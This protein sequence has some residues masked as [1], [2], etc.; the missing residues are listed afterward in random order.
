MVASSDDIQAGMDVYGSDGEKI[1]TVHS[2]NTGE[3]GS[4]ADTAAGY[5]GGG[6]GALGD[7]SRVYS[8]TGTGGG[9]G[10]LGDESRVY[11]DT[12]TGGGPGS[13]GDES[14]VDN[15]YAATGTTSGTGSDTGATSAVTGGMGAGDLGP[16]M[17]VEEI[18]VVE[19]VPGSSYTATTGGGMAGGQ[20]GGYFE[21]DHGGF[22]GIGTQHLYIPYSAVQSVEPGSSVTLNC[23]KD[24]CANLYQNNPAQI[25]Q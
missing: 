4:D 13:L 7:E 5:S 24:E 18:E 19:I 22:L 1:G 12:G 9:P 10:A 20:P 21:V 23:T 6:P 16:E 14:R 11:D 15:D 25:G 2:I 17:V 3:I 8:D